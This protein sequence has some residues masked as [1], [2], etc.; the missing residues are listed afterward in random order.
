MASLVAAVSWTS[1][2]EAAKIACVGDST[3]YGYGLTNRASESYPAVLEGLL[4]AT[5][6]VQNFGVSGCTLLKNGDK[7]YWKEGTFSSSDNFDPD[8][9][10]VMLGTNDAKPQ[11]WSHKAE[12]SSDYLALIDHYRALGALVYVAAPP[13]VYDPGAFDIAPTVVASE[14]VPLLRQIATHCGWYRA[15]Q[16]EL[17]GAGRGNGRDEL[18][19]D[20]E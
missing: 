16:R 5:H 3:T 15:W 6:T 10:I 9:V 17:G 12:F 18:I 8:V 11:N 20:C 13:P 7:P 1:G 14:V 19:V 2:A 4:G